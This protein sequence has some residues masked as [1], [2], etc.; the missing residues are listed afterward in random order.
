MQCALSVYGTLP[1]VGIADLPRALETLVGPDWLWGIGQELGI[2][3]IANVNREFFGSCG[4][5]LPPLEP[6]DCG[7]EQPLAARQLLP[8]FLPAAGVNDSGQIIGTQV[9]PEE[10][11]RGFSYQQGARDV[12]MEVIQHEHINAPIE[13]A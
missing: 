7:N 3:C 9:S 1:V 5:K 10:L 6:V 12:R 2:R 13:S 11:F 8:G 4:R